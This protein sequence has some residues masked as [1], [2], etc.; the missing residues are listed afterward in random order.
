MDFSPPPTPQA[1]LLGLNPALWLVIAA[2]TAYAVL[3]AYHINAC[4][5][6]SDSSGYM[7]HAKLLAE[8]R[9]HATERII[10]GVNYRI[11][12]S[13][14]Y[15]PLGLKPASHFEGLVPTYPPGLALMLMAIS[16]LSGWVHA[17]DAVI[18]LHS[19]AGI[20]LIFILALTLGL[21]VRLSTLASVILAT[22]PLYL[23]YSVQM[24]SDLPALVWV[25]LA[26]LTAWKSSHAESKTMQS[27]W[28][29][30]CGFAV[31][32]AV[33]IRPTNAL[34]FIPVLIALGL[35]PRRFFNFIVGGLPGA[36]FFAYHSQAAY[37]HIGTTGYGDT[38]TLFES[39]YFTQT[40]YHYIHWLPILFTPLSLLSCGLILLLK[41]ST[42]LSLVLISWA[43]VYLGFYSFYSCTHETWWYL[44]FILPA[45]PA[46]IVGGLLSLRFLLTWV[47]LNNTSH[48]YLRIG[49]LSLGL[50]LVLPSAF[51]TKKLGAL[52]AGRGESVYPKTAAWLTEN[53]PSSS[54]I[55]CM[56][57]S[58]ALFYYTPFTLIRWDEIDLDLK[59]Q[60]IAKTT[61]QKLPLYAALFNWEKD[62]ALTQ[63]F[64][65]HWIKRTSIK[66]VTVWERKDD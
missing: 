57:E 52:N 13:Y 11:S 29:Y 56:Q 7:N 35:R 33:L 4:A 64:P 12:H 5:G 42:Q 66:E 3:I 26:V 21:S 61:A 24:M 50:L 17:G 23:N 54:V 44:R 2:L 28:A 40:L 25:T 59:N 31:S 9:L 48:S 10:P 22:S 19:L 20:V 15:T 32:V 58:G 43:F 14:L 8:G 65:G 63:R 41:K 62:E 18:L 16:P 34:I 38:W 51:W 39:T 30:L 60:I 1:K 37:G 46:L 27:G 55:L 6:G 36:L 45:A 49:Y 53:I 47:N